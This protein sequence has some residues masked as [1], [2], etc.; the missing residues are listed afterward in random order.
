MNKYGAGS[1]VFV[2]F[3][4]SN[5][6]LNCNVEA[7]KDIVACG[8]ATE[9]D[10]NLLLKVR[11]PSRSGLQVLCIVL[12]GYKYTYK[13]PWTGKPFDF[14]VTHKFIGVATKGDT[15]PNI[16]KA[17]MSLSDAGI[18][19]GDADTGSNWKNPT[20]NAW[21]DFDWIRYA[22]QKADTEEEAINLLT[23]D[24]VKKLHASGVSENLFVVGPKK[25]YV[26]EADAFHY[27]IK[28][29]NNGVVA[30]SNYPK[31]LWKTQRL[32][33]MPIAHSFD[34]TVEK[35][36][37]KGQTV[38]LKSL[39]GIKILD[40]GSDYVS[41]KPVPFIHALE[42]NSINMVY[43]IQLGERESVGHFSVKLLDIESNK[44]KI[45]MCYMFKAWEDEVL[46]H[47]EP[48]YGSLTVKDMINFSRLHSEDLDGLRPLCQDTYEYEAAAVYKVPNENYEIM[49]SGWFSANHA[50]SSIYVPFHICDND[51]YDP[52]ET[53]E[54]AKLSLDLLDRYG[55]DTLTPYF[56][57]I[58][59]VFL[60][61]TDFIEEMATELTANNRDDITSDF[62][63]IV[64]NGMQREAWLTEEIW[65][66]ISKISDQK[67]KQKIID[68]IGN[69]WE[70]DYIFSLDKMRKTL[71]DDA[72]KIK[73]SSIIVDKIENIAVDICKTKIDATDAIGKQSPT[74]KEEYEIGKK[75]IKQGEYEQG[76]NL[77]EKTFTECD[78]LMKGQIPTES[79]NEKSEEKA[80][81]LFYLLIAFLVLAF[82]ILL[83]KMKPDLD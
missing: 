12:E 23:E 25:G 70:K 45:S 3:L 46:S 15:I 24:V 30:M 58:E 56:S 18:A 51:I 21:D 40:V 49:S 32:K 4:F 54:A 31:E 61:E 37:R 22:C 34:A 63:T 69:I 28:E 33:K 7:C 13:Y 78:M 64:D 20:K 83:L 6:F 48:S 19:Y 66:E 74:A 71:T 80:D 14:T 57:K 11:D 76:F 77:L 17:G 59:N 2:L 62:L 44:A 82:V 47:I 81:V 36:V 38:R 65:M 8:D 60:N 53:G 35:T 29:F 50:C 26:V 55:H 52:Y 73:K 10:Y 5:I 79:T 16:V 41:V 68:V 67:D 75:L 9:G 1:V 72:S 42:T 27:D 39:Q 43:T